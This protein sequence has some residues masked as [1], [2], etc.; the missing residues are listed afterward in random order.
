MMIRFSYF[1]L[2]LAFTTAFMA[3]NY[4]KAGESFSFQSTGKWET[5]GD[6]LSCTIK[7]RMDNG[8]IISFKRNQNRYKNDQTLLIDFIQPAFKPQESFDI[9][10]SVDKQKQSL[11]ST[12]ISDSVLSV[13]ISKGGDP[14]LNAI[15]DQSKVTINLQGQEFTFNLGGYQDAESGLENCKT[16]VKETQYKSQ[17]PPVDEEFHIGDNA[18]AKKPLS[19][20]TKTETAQ[21]FESKESR[22]YIK[23]K[24]P[25]DNTKL[26]DPTPI[27]A[28]PIIQEPLAPAKNDPVAIK[29]NTSKENKSVPLASNAPVPPKKMHLSNDKIFKVQ[30]TDP[31]FYPQPKEFKE[32]DDASTGKVQDI[33]ASQATSA[34]W[35]IEKATRLYQESERMNKKLGQMLLEKERECNVTISD[36]EAV[37]MNG[38]APSTSVAGKKSAYTL[39]LEKEIQNLKT[40]LQI[41]KNLNQQKMNNQP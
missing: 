39:E 6:D 31:L 24:D 1:F 7:T 32:D 29:P 34:D 19:S 18:T 17:K 3:P 8:Y 22:N 16:S 37:L 33:P 14:L 41:Q 15:H 10:T 35:N 13:P 36:M 12:A 23:E 30:K 28:Q 21:S 25:V 5:T 38:S 20:E 27:I 9:V 26:P 40:E 4:A 2:T 11:K